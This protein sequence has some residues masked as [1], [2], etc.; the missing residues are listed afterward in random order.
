[1][2]K[3]FLGFPARGLVTIPAQLCMFQYNV[4]CLWNWIRDLTVHFTYITLL[5]PTAVLM[6]CSSVRLD[7]ACF[8]AKHMYLL[9]ACYTLHPTQ[10]V[11]SNQNIFQHSACSEKRYWATNLPYILE[12][13]PQPFYSFRGLK[14]QMQIRI[15]CGLDSR[16]WARFWKKYRAAVR[17]ARTIQLYNILYNI[18][19]LL[20]IR[21][22]VI[23]HNW[24][25]LSCRQGTVEGKVRIRTAN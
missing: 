13:N 10:P 6:T 18:Y 5:F 17:A 15:A 12:S 2:P 3:W 11:W 21:L 23:T 4:Y 25:S 8:N 9:A 16:S 20:F 22:A 14:N 19:N 1:M 24:I 7:L